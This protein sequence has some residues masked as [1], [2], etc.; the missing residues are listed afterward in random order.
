MNAPDPAKLE[1]FRERL[2]Q[3][4]TDAETVNAWRKWHPKMTPFMR[5]ATEAGFPPNQPPRDGNH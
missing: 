4:W 1:R 3:E 5:G 2:T